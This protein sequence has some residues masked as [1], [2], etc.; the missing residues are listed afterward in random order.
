M[1]GLAAR[2]AVSM[3]SA[4]CF[5]GEAGLCS[6]L[7]GGEGRKF[8]GGGIVGLSFGGVIGAQRLLSMI[9]VETDG[10]REGS[11]P[12]CAVLCG[13]WSGSRLMRRLRRESDVSGELGA[14]GVGAQLAFLGELAAIGDDKWLVRLGHEYS[15]F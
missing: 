6:S 13:G 4:V 1:P 12:L 9:G 14:D 10:V 8:G 7:L 2:M 3:R 11:T 5:V 15:A